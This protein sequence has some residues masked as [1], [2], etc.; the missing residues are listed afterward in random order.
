MVDIV[1]RSEVE[2]DFANAIEAPLAPL[3]HT[4]LALRDEKGGLGRITLDLPF[5]LRRFAQLRVAC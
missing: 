1:L 2:R 3:S 5:A 4:E